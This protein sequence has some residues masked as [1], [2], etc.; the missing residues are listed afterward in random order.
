M[1]LWRALSQL[2]A[3]VPRSVQR[4]AQGHGS[5]L[6]SP[7]DQAK[8]PSGVSDRYVSLAPAAAGQIIIMTA[9]IA[10]GEPL[11]I[12][13]R[14][15]SVSLAVRVVVRLYLRIKAPTQE[16]SGVVVSSDL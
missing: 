7:G 9:S 4:D 2:T 16:W 8:M 5:G 1:R 10:E 15:I 13:F 12:A 11:L 3:G 14:A 6:I